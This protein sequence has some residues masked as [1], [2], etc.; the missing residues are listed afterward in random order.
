[1]SRSIWKFI[2]INKKNII[3]N[4]KKIVTIYSRS[5][6]ITQEYIGYTV[7]IYNGIRFYDINVVDKMVGHK[8]GEFSPTRKYPKHKKKK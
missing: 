1:M 3:N 7:K 6:I 5:N 8:F 4:D 2:Y